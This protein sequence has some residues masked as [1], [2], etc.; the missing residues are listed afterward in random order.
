MN[1]EE[2]AAERM[3]NISA[4]TG[5]TSREV[6][7]AMMTLAPYMQE[8]WDRAINDDALWKERAKHYGW[9]RTWWLRRQLR[10]RG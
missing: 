10:K 7:D 9:L 1:E 4:A 6:F 3:Y 2:Q 8:A 5:Y